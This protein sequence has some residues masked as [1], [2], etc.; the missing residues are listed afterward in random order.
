MAWSLTLALHGYQKSLVR[1]EP[2]G[3]LPDV[4]R[5]ISLCGGEEIPSAVT[6][7]PWG[8]RT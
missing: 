1:G 4:L 8:G 3:R 7:R 2:W 5:M 6:Q